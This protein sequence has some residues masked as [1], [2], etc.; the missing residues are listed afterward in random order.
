MKLRVFLNPELD[1]RWMFNAVTLVA[2]APVADGLA[3]AP[4]GWVQHPAKSQ[5]PSYAVTW[6]IQQYLL[7]GVQY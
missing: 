4:N 6:M 2:D 3:E 7:E 1:G 5:S